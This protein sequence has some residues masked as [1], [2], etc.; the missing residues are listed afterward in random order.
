M[1]DLAKELERLDAQPVEI[2]NNVGMLKIKSAND[3]ISGAKSRPQPTDLWN[4]LWFE[5]EVCCL[6]AD[7]NIG[8]SI[9]A[10][11]IASHIAESRSVLYFDFE[12]S[13]KQFQLRYTNEDVSFGFPNN[14]YRVEIDSEQFTLDNMDNFEDCI[15]KDIERCAVGY[16]A[17]IIIIDNITFLCSAAEKSEFAGRLMMRLIALKKKHGLSILVLAHT[18]K[19]NLASP[20]TQNDMAGSKRLMNFFDSAFTIG[21]SAKDSGLRYIKQVKVRFGGYSYDT[22]NVM[23]CQIVK[24][25]DGFLHFETIGYCAEREHLKEQSENDRADLEA[26]VKKLLEQNKSVRAIASE[27]GIS[28]S[29]SQR[30]IEKIKQK[31]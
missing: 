25:S 7:T 1:T 11:Q 18:P 19:R 30:I 10:V 9:Y 22:D 15:I 28:S 23:T 8:K 21:Q 27:L 3:W 6:F 2:P 13:D 5:N 20:I 24:T 16:G 29:K 14:F 12:L 4:G 17:K 31:E 26:R